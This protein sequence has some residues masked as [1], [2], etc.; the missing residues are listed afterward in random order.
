MKNTVQKYTFYVMQHNSFLPFVNFI[1]HIKILDLNSKT[2][3]FTFEGY[4]LISLSAVLRFSFRRIGKSC[5]PIPLPK[6]EK[7]IQPS[8]FFTAISNFNCTFVANSK[9]DKFYGIQIR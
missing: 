3:L 4:M 8:L 9:I 7:T 1:S 6:V 2:N 5:L